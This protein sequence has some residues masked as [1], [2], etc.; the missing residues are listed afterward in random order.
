MNRRTIF[1]LMT[2]TL[3]RV[4]VLAQEPKPPVFAYRSFWPEFAAMK[5]SRM[6]A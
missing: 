4:A 2:A 1:T 5:Q 3:L 6:R